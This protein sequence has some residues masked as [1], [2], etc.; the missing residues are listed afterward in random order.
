RR[1]SR[2]PA[3]GKDR[4]EAD[5]ADAG[6]GRLPW[7]GGRRPVQARALPLLIA[8][9]CGKER[10]P[11]GARFFWTHA[12]LRI[13]EFAVMPA[14]RA[15]VQTRETAPERRGRIGL[16]SAAVR[17]LTTLLPRARADRAHAD[18]GMPR[19]PRHAYA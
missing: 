12:A 15:V 6:A 8:P 16:D 4:R 11:C 2:A 10:A 13:A 14:A 7:R 1:G 3:S 5:E 19:L 9:G 17:R 18:Q